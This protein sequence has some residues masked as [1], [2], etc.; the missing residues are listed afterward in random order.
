MDDRR[1]IEAA[2]HEVAD[3][4][5]KNRAQHFNTSDRYEEQGERVARDDDSLSREITASA[6]EES[7][8]SGDVTNIFHD[9]SGLSRHEG[10]EDCE[11]LVKATLAR[12]A[13]AHRDGLLPACNAHTSAA[14]DEQKLEDSKTTNRGRPLALKPECSPSSAKSRRVTQ[15]P[16]LGRLDSDVHPIV[17]I[18][19]G[20]PEVVARLWPPER[21]VMGLRVCKWVREHL[22]RN[23]ERV[24]LQ[25]P[26]RPQA[27][28]GPADLHTDL[29]HL[30]LCK[31]SL[32]C[33]VAGKLGRVL[34]ERCQ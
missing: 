6:H 7:A 21:V 33:K 3:H 23:A 22:S 20:Q 4:D 24:V 9:Q 15:P 18:L 12:D 16:D 31:N 29:V 2:S 14:G 11:A 5:L 25:L 17:R 28:V 19:D 34:A 32:D 30:D 10:T 27:S 1:R 26:L 8:L 13:K